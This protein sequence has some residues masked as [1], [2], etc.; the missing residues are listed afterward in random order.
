MVILDAATG[1]VLSNEILVAVAPERLCRFQKARLAQ[2]QLYKRTQVLRS[3]DNLY[4]TMVTGHMYLGLE[5][6]I[7]CGV[8]RVQISNYGN[9]A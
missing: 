7:M 5:M 3:R 1:D 4:V 8:T 2:A 9:R 6:F